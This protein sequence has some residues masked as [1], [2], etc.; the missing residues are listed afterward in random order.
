MKNQ[1]V[2][3][4]LGKVSAFAQSTDLQRFVKHPAFRLAE[5]FRP[6]TQHA[7]NLHTPLLA[8]F[9]T[10]Q[11]GNGNRVSKLKPRSQRGRGNL[12]DFISIPSRSPNVYM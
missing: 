7:Q 3:V 2:N 6:R 12:W 1:V 5:N 11:A 10:K 9:I 4:A 8:C